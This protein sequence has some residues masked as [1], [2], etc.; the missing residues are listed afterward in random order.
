ML[1]ASRK[2]KCQQYLEQ[3][4]I[5]SISICSP[6]WYESMRERYSGHL[7]ELN[8]GGIEVEMP[9][10][11]VLTNEDHAENTRF[12]MRTFAMKKRLGGHGW[13]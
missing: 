1:K 10:P 2:L 3:I 6:K 9:E 4:D 12:L 8:N 5:Q 7:N 13:R 11:R